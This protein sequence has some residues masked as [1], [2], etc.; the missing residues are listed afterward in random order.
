VDFGIDRIF[1]DME[2]L[3]D[4]PVFQVVKTAEFKYYLTWIGQPFNAFL[5]LF[6]QLGKFQ[7]E[8]FKG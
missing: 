5:Q 2:L 1:G 4:L 8:P 7:L 3:S 6:Q